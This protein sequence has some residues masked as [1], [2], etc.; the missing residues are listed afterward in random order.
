M[1]SLF[2]IDREAAASAWL[3]NDIVETVYCIAAKENSILY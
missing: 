3:K 1:L 2:K